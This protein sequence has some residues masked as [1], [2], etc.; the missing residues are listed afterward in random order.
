[1]IK[2]KGILKLRNEKKYNINHADA[3]ILSQTLKRVFRHDNNSDSHGNYRV[4]SLYF[5]TLYDKALIQNIS[6]INQREKF[7]IRYYNNDFSFIRL[8]RKIKING[9]CA[10]QTALLAQSEV[11][12]I[13]NGEIDFLLQKEDALTIEFYSK[14]KGQLLKPKTIVTYDREAFIYHPG[15]VRITIDRNLRTTTKTDDF[16]QINKHINVSDGLAVLEVKYDEFLPDLVKMAV[17]LNNRPLTA[18]SKYTMCRKY[19]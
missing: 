5:D 4:S 13:L 11:Q 7:R 17:C 3:F 10:K 9:K 14:L 15:N 1:M 19:D 12:Q 6:G 2:K 8:E 18:Y 16:L